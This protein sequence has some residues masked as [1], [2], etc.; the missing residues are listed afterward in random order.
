M[1][2]IVTAGKDLYNYSSADILRHLY[3]RET[4]YPNDCVER[5]CKVRQLENEVDILSNAPNSHCCTEVV[6]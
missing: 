3:A 4:D 2:L 1:G 5:V 6:F